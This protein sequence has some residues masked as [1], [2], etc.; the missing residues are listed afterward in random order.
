MRLSVVKHEVFEGPGGIADWA[1]ERGHSVRV[2]ELSKGEALP[3]L[4]DFDALVLMGGPMSVNEEDRYAWLKPEK[5]LVREA[6]AGGKKILGVCLGSQMIA[7]ALGATVR[8]NA[9]KEIGWFPIEST[10]AGKA[11]PWWGR[12]PSTL[13][14]F[15]WHGE[16]FDLPPGA[17][18]LARS[19]ACEHQVYAIGDRVLALQCHLEVNADSLSDMVALGRDEIDLSQPFIQN[20]SVLLGQPEAFARLLPLFQS[21]MDAWAGA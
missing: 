14:V 6:L 17:E 18:L 21:V 8:P 1:R 2:V 19:S 10:A 4:G 7:S 3:A 15:H 16:T 12:M 13:P 5:A 11:H 20:E 9:F